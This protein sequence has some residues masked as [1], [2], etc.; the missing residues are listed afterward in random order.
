MQQIIWKWPFSFRGEYN[1]RITDI[2]F[3][4]PRKMIYFFMP[5][6]AALLKYKMNKGNQK[7]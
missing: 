2:N 4:C 5:G 7:Y 3:L 6:A 1:G